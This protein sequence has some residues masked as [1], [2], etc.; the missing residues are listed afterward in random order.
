MMLLERKQKE[1]SCTI[2]VIVLPYKLSKSWSETGGMKWVQRDAYLIRVR[3]M[4]QWEEPKL[5]R[6]RVERDT[7]LEMSDRTK[8]IER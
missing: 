1:I 4:K 5:I 7:E 3:T 2:L 6:E 8:K